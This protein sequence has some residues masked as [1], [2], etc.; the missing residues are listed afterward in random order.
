LFG[1][2]YNLASKDTEITCGEDLLTELDLEV[3]YENV[4]NSIANYKRFPAPTD[5]E[6]LATFRTRYLRDKKQSVPHDL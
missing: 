4:E 3:D 1:E 6:T 2:E 5:D